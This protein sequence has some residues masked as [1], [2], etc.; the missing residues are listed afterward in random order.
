MSRFV[1]L[2]VPLESGQATQ[3]LL[4]S[5]DRENICRRCRDESTVVSING[6]LFLVG[7]CSSCSFDSCFTNGLGIRIINDVTISEFFSNE[8]SYTM[9]MKTWIDAYMSDDLSKYID[10]YY[11]YFEVEKR[12]S[13]LLDNCC[14][15]DSGN[16]LSEKALRL[17]RH[18]L[19]L[20]SD[21]ESLTIG[22]RRIKR[23]KKNL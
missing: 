2:M 14:I 12:I 10:K 11:S 21:M 16:T 3:I 15:L 13:Y 8:S 23:A 19:D 9:T 5:I 7:Q 18:K 20:V 6:Q 1:S 22:N 4:E 17:A